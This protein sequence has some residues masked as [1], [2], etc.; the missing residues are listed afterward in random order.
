MCQKVANE[1][2][3]FAELTRMKR[4]GR[5]TLD[6]PRCATDKPAL[7]ANDH[8]LAVKLLTL[9][10]NLSPESTEALT[11]LAAAQLAAGDKESAA[12]ALRKTRQIDP[13][14]WLIRK[15]IRA[16]EH[17]EKFYDGPVDFRWQCE[18]MRRESKQGE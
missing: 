13:K 18:Q 4:C 16:I 5:W 17:P 10:A 11:T 14:N 6:R 7:A 9:A 8:A 2:P 3:V 12:Q 15:Q 1:R